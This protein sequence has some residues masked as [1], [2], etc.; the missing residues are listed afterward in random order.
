MYLDRAPPPGGGPPELGVVVVTGGGGVDGKSRVE[1]VD[2]GSLGVSGSVLGSSGALS[3]G[4]GVEIEGLAAEGAAGME[5][6]G[7]TGAGLNCAR[8]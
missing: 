8:A 6:I 3:V 2:A 1:G 4:V 5:C 7:V